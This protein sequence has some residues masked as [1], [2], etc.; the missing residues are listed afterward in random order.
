MEHGRVNRRGLDDLLLRRG[1][2]KCVVQ[3]SC[4]W[5]VLNFSLLLPL[6]RRDGSKWPLW[7]QLSDRVLACGRVVFSLGK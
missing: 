1:Y 6:R 7:F 4:P 2:V 3:L 5:Q